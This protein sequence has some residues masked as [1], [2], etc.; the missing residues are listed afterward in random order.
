MATVLDGEVCPIPTSL[1]VTDSDAGPPNPAFG[2]NFNPLRAL[3]MLARLPVNV[4]VGA[5]MPAPPVNVSP[6]SSER[7]ISPSVPETVSDTGTDWVLGSPSPIKI[8][9]ASENTKAALVF[10]SCAEGTVA[11]RSSIS[12]TD[13]L[14]LRFPL[15]ARMVAMPMPAP[16]PCTGRWNRLNRYCPGSTT[17][18]PVASPGGRRIDRVPPRQIARPRLR[19]RLEFAGVTAM[20][21]KVA[22]TWTETLLVVLC[23]GVHDPDQEAVGPGAEGRGYVLGR[24]GAVRRETHRPGGFPVVLQM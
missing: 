5:S 6:A 1:M 8:A 16:A 20:P 24:V 10:V 13:A 9:F 2:V 23:L 17:R 22:T 4:I 12:A 21:A 18:M 7:E 3:S 14:P 15:V 19:S 11:E